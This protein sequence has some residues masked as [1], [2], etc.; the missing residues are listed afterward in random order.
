MRYLLLAVSLFSFTC[1]AAP[2]GRPLTVVLLNSPYPPYVLD[3]EQGTG[4]VLDILNV[5]SQTTSTLLAIEYA[6]EVRTLKLIETQQVDARIESEAWFL[7]KTKHCWS[8]P[9][10]NVD[11]VVV[12]RQGTHLAENTAFLGMVM[13]GRYGYTYPKFEAL[14]AKGQVER[15]DFY[16]EFDILFALAKGEISQ[17]QFG[18]VAKPTLEWYQLRYPVL[19]EQVRVFNVID[20]APLQ[21]QFAANANAEQAC[22]HFNAFLDDF[23][24]TDAY[25]QILMQ[26]QPD[27]KD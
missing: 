9:L 25:Y 3:P 16:S 18:I 5:Y 8:R 27:N 24:G 19:Q 4:I 12:V 26:Y 15:R 2:L 20:S 7:G 23:L 1:L 6:P 13:F 21:L 17:A 22:Q 10:L 14:V 11:D